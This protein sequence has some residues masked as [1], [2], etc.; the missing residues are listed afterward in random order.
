[1]AG[2]ATFRIGAGASAGGGGGADPH[3]YYKLVMTATQGGGVQG[4]GHLQLFDTIGGSDFLRAA[5]LATTATVTATS[6]FGGFPISN[7]TDNDDSTAW[8]STS[9]SDT[10][11][12]DLGA[13]PADWK[14]VHEISVMPRYAQLNQGPKDLSWHHSDDGSSY[15]SRFSLTDISIRVTGTPGEGVRLRTPGQYP[16]PAAGYH[17]RWGLNLKTTDSSLFDIQWAELRNSIG[18]ANRCTGGQPQARLQFSTSFDPDRGWNG[19]AGVRYAAA[20]IPSLLWYEHFD[21]NEQPKP[22]QIAI[23]ADAT[24]ANRA[25]RTFDLV[26]QDYNGGTVTVQESFSTG[27]WSTPNEIRTF[28]VA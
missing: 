6:T 27:A 24:N 22:A 1:M 21:G 12:I 26:Y 23:K 7:L 25:P 10:V 4:L 18:G 16:T 3:R 9:T 14:D 13:N 11:F 8:L 2:C 17:R 19:A 20:N 15:T 5:V 28:A